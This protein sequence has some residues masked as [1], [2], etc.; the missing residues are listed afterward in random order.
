MD[1]LERLGFILLILLWVTAGVFWYIERDSEWYKTRKRL[2]DVVG[3]IV[4]IL[5]Y[6][7]LFYNPGN[8]G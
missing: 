3:T 6:F 2:W 1:M 8:R 7:L 4:F 5:P